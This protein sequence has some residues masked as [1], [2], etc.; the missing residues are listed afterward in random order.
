MILV[1]GS[2]AYDYIFNFPGKF[3]EHII[4]DKLHIL[5]VSFLVENMRKGFGGIA[6]NIAYSLALL[7]SEVSILGIAG[8]DFS[9][10]RVFLEKSNVDT[11]YIHTTNELFTSTAFGIA[12]KKNN[13]IWGYYMGADTLSP[14]LSLSVIKEKIH[15]GIIAPQNPKTM[16]KLAREY[17]KEK[18]PYLFDAGMQLPWLTGTDLLSAFKGAKI[19]IGNDYEVAVMEKK[20]K[21]KNLSALTASGKIIITTL[22]EKGSQ[23]AYRKE[24]H[25][26]KSAK[27]KSITDPAGAGDAYRAGFMAG[28]IRN[29]PF[30]VCGQMGSVAAAY[31]VEKYG[32]TTHYYSLKEFKKRYFENFHERLQL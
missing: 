30:Q 15:F 10:Y 20:T 28:Y 12:D 9:P 24:M 26:I 11:R 22:G 21:I 32:T 25:L 8:S 14:T 18:I 16:L 31:T 27:V 13:T 19:I 7:G 3:A 1:S 4:P 29:F 5:N 17:T 2:L 6:G 23:I